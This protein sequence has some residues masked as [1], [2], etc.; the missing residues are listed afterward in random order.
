MITWLPF[1]LYNSTHVV[2]LI[3]LFLLIDFTARG[4]GHEVCHKDDMH[5][6]LEDFNVG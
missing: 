2:P 4:A 6:V 3:L 5:E 1:T